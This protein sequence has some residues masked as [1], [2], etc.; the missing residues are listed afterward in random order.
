MQELDMTQLA[1]VCGGESLGQVLDAAHSALDVPLG[2][3]YDA[4][5]AFIRDHEFFHQGVMDKSIGIAGRHFRNVP[6]VGPTRIIG[7]LLRGDRLAVAKGVEVT[8]GTWDAA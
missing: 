6:F 8:R 5:K 4:T 7:G 1:T 2:Q 3:T